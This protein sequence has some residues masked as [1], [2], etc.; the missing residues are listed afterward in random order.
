MAAMSALPIPLPATPSLPPDPELRRWA[1]CIRQTAQDRSALWIRGGGSKAFVCGAPPPDAPILDTRTHRGIVSY[2]PT[3]LVVTVRAGTPLAELEAALAERGQQLAFEPPQYAPG[4]TVG[5][6][7]AAGF[8]GPARASVGSVRDFVLGAH[9]LNGQGEWLALGGQVMKNVA[10]YDLSRLLAGSMGTLGVLTQV[11]LKVLPQAPAEATLRFGWS[12]AEALE[13]L[14]R[15]RGQPLPLNAS[16]WLREPD[17]LSGTLYLRLRG[18]VAAVE[19]ACRSLTLQGAGERLDPAVTTPDWAACRDQRLPFFL[20][21]PG[22]LAALWRLSVAPC[23]P[24]LQALWPTLVEWHGG[25][26][27]VWAPVDEGPALRAWAQAHGG[28]ATLFRL[29]ATSTQPAPHR[30]TAP[31]GALRDIHR[32]VQAAFDPAG[33]FNPGAWGFGI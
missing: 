33:I 8:S 2:E 18:A 10:G 21:P 28:H 6:M 7:V 14:A 24:A 4:T 22:P 1:E 32:R 19:A 29:P 30:F 3:E 26:R 25:L 31:A 16:C 13:R 20:N 12:Q 17:R 11:S 15:W 5:G 9:L 23:T 27:W